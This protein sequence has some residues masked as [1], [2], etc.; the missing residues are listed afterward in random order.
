MPVIE[1]TRQL[2]TAQK[3][4][5][6]FAPI[7]PYLQGTGGLFSRFDRENPV[8][9]ALMG[10]NAGVAENIPVF[11]GSRD[12]DN[13]FGGTEW[14][15]ESLITG[16]TAGNLDTFANQPTLPCVDG[17]TAGLL[18]FCS[19]ANT[20]G[21]Y[22]MSTREVYDDRAGRIASM[23]NE[24]TVQVANAFPRPVFGTPSTT[25]SLQNAVSNELASRIWEMILGFQRMFYPRVFI[26]SPA[27]NVGEA[28]DIVGLDLHINKGNK[29]D[30]LTGNS[31][32][33]ADSDVKSFGSQLI[34][35]A[36]NIMRYLEMT[37]AYCMYKARRQGLGDPVYMIAMRPELW[38]EITKI[39]PVTALLETI[40]SINNLTNGRANVDGQEMLRM[41]DELRSSMMIPLN[42]RLVRVVVDDTIAETSL[43][44]ILGVPTYSSTIYGI[45]LTVLGGMPVTFWEYFN[46]ANNQALS[47]QQM[48]GGF[49]WTTDGGMFK[50]T[51]DFAKGCLKLNATF[52]PRL[53][54]R[55]PQIAWR[56]DNV[57]YQ[58]LQHFSSWD[59]TSSYF[60]NGGPSTGGGQKYYTEW[61]TSTPVYPQIP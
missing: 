38:Q 39:I 29:V 43:G 4:D 8:F 45:P 52:T 24:F 33:A 40:A 47:I 20:S 61:S 14:A 13:E 21:N 9:S 19:I 18:K 1:D 57:A 2:G 51:S 16:Q 46:H 3:N 53:R 10:P 58:P 55:T 22:R 15:F 5:P 48:A 35:G 30:S 26:G 25:P 17:P 32:T 31:C 54:M 59:P 42:G 49:R 37:D 56:V 36:G 44:N 34:T 11:N 60:Q 27:N 23:A 7:A 50:W 6:P 41:R 12:L 28:R